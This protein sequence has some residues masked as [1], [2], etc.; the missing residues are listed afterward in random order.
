MA[1]KIPLG[2]EQFAIVDDEDFELVNQYQWRGHKGGNSDNHIYAVTRLRMHRL[3]MQAPPGM[4]VDHIN[5]DTLDN[6]KCNLRLCTT[7]QNQQNSRPRKGTSRYKGVSYNAKK[8]KWL[9]A[10][11]ANGKVHYVGCFTSEEQWAKA[12]DKKRK[13]VCGDYATTNLWYDD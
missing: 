7:S 3:V 10:F 11:M 6:R 12:V 2:D 8:K 13:E 9:G 1:K 5:G 4:V